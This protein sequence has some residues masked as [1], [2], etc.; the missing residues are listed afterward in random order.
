MQ[1]VTLVQIK[2]EKT[3]HELLAEPELEGLLLPFA[4]NGNR[5]LAVLAGD[6]SALRRVL[7]ERNIDVK[8]QLD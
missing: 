7:A 3:L 1:S 5:A 8:E 4:P 2:D 6:L